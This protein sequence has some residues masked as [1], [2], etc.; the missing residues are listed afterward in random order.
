MAGAAVRGGEEGALQEDHRVP[1]GPS[2]GLVNVIDMILHDNIS[3]TIVDIDIS[4][5]L[6]NTIRYIFLYK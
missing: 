2:R 4:R 6:M 5:Y 1:C 3:I